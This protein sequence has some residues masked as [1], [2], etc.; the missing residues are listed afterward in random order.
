MS[1]GGRGAK[2]LAFAIPPH[3][4]TF[5]YLSFGSERLLNSAIGLATYIGNHCQ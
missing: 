3:L 5:R 1:G 2:Y 4:R